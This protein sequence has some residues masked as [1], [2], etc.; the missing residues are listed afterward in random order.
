MLKDCANF[1]AQLGDASSVFMFR[2]LCIQI[3]VAT[4]N[5]SLINSFQPEVNTEDVSDY[6]A[7]PVVPLKK[8][9]LNF[10]PIL[11]DWEQQAIEVF[12]ESAKDGSPIHVVR[13]PARTPLRLRT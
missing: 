4:L 13:R 2:E 12:E 9:H 7:R 3:H 10:A 6:T 1:S 8:S 11:S 5:L